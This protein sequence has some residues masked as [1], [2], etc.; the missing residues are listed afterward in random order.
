MSQ[1][2]V[3]LVVAMVAAGGT[4]ALATP[5]GGEEGTAVVAVGDPPAGPSPDVSEA[6][7]RLRGALVDRASGVLG[8]AALRDRLAGTS[9]PATLTELERAYVGGQAAFQADEIDSALRAFRAIVADLERSPESRE[10]YALWL[11]AHLRIALAERALDHPREMVAAMERVIA[12]EPG[13]VVDPEQYA[14]S[15]RSGSASSR[16]RD[17]RSPSAPRPVP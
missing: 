2:A 12:V 5:G 15:S 17:E 7:H 13:L 1:L 6:A 3:Q 4:P 11:R 10:S 14:P 8:A 16:R 9:S